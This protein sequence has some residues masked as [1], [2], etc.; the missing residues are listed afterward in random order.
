VTD[1]TLHQAAL[2]EFRREQIAEE[3]EEEIERR[4]EDLDSWSLREVVDFVA[5]RL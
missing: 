1:L 3:I 4:E 2:R 5:D